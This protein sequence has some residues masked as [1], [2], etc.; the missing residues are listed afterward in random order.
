M[1][2]SSQ[3]TTDSLV[4]R[5]KYYSNKLVFMYV[6]AG[7]C[8]AC[9]TFSFIS[10]YMH[11]YA[12]AKFRTPRVECSSQCCRS[13]GSLGGGAPLLQTLGGLS[14][15]STL[16]NREFIMSQRRFSHLAILNTECV[17]DMSPRTA[18]EN[19]TLVHLQSR[20]SVTISTKIFSFDL[21]NSS[22][23][24]QSFEL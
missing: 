7:S 20:I 13:G 6:I 9:G 22:R 16:E 19:V 3:N 4:P 8:H 11:L 1:Q 18:R 14:P 15:P 5:S 12:R 17:Q 21:K 23:I 24:S 10:P 2:R